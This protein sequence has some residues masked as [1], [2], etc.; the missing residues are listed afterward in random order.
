[1]KPSYDY[2]ERWANTTPPESK[3]I[4]R[5]CLPTAAILPSVISLS[6]C[7]RIGSKCHTQPKTQRDKR[8]AAAVPARER[9]AISSQLTHKGKPPFKDHVVWS[10]NKCSTFSRP[11]PVH[12]ATRNWPDCQ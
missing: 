3:M 9:D 6:R 11:Y 1:M 8:K 5:P 7:F 12:R 4:R 2:G 10:I